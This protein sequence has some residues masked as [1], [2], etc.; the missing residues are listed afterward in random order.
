M[1][2][3]RLTDEVLLSEE[4]PKAALK[5]CLDDDPR[6]MGLD[7]KVFIWY[8]YGIHYIYR[9]LMARSTSMM[10]MQD[11]RLESAEFQLEQSM[12]ENDAGG[13]SPIQSLL[14]SEPP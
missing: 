9:S 8:S 12:T 10:P 4:K 13:L 6:L 11:V 7:P 1:E 14:H 3:Y 5:T 2:T